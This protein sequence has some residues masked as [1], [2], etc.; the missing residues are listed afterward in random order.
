MKIQVTIDCSEPH[1]LVEFWAAALGYEVENNSALVESLLASRRISE[2]LA[3][4]TR[5][6]RGF[7]DLAACV[8]PER[9]RPRLLFQKVPESKVVK[10]RV[11]LDLQVGEERAPAE[12]ARIQEL[13]AT[14][15]Q[16][17]SDKGAPTTT[18]LDPEGNEF[19]VS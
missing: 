2:E 16:V 11:H 15:F 4:P 12:I 19:C 10:N 7:R 3:V 13:G 18:M 8:D 9:V 14:I 1:R 17:T 6:G 5:H